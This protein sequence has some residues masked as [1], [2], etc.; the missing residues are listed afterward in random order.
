MPSNDASQ[1]QQAAADRRLR[2]EIRA[3]AERAHGASKERK[4]RRGHALFEKE[5]SMVVIVVALSLF[6]LSDFLTPSLYLY[7]CLPPPPTKHSRA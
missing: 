3:V 1:R 5:T 2:D 6:S 7:L 4:G